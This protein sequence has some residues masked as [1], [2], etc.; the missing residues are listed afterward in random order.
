MLLHWTIGITCKS[1]SK[2]FRRLCYASEVWKDA[3]QWLCEGRSLEISANVNA[4]QLHS[5]ER[6][7]SLAWTPHCC[8]CERI[9]DG[10]DGVMN[11]QRDAEGENAS[12]GQGEEE[13]RGWGREPWQA[14]E[15]KPRAKACGKDEPH[16]SLPSSGL[17]SAERRALRMRSE[18]KGWLWNSTFKGRI[19]HLYCGCQIKVLMVYVVHWRIPQCVYID[20][21]SEFFC[22]QSPGSCAYMY[23]NALREQRLH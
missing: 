5:S 23:H 19:R 6:A 16:S 11:R 14:K 18:M 21:E 10:E 17:L 15:R 2:L 4:A 12:H 20:W 1:L 8:L 9:I 7:A 22:S 3:W 13:G